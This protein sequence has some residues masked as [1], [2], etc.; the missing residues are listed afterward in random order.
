MSYAVENP[1]YVKANDYATVTAPRTVPNTATSTTDSSTDNATTSA[2]EPSHSIRPNI[3]VA[4][5]ELARMATE[6]EESSIAA[7]V[8]GLQEGAVVGGDGSS[9][10]RRDPRAFLKRCGKALKK[11]R[12]F[13]KKEN[14]DA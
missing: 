10:H 8:T 11:K 2:G 13:W 6:S 4:Y 3:D 14:K 7:P 9:L 12:S 1:Y 5:A